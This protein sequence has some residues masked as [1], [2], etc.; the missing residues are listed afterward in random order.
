MP[1]GCGPA[2]VARRVGISRM[3]VYRILGEIAGPKG[4]GQAV[5]SRK[6]H[7]PASPVSQPRSR[8]S[9]SARRRS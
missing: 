1:E 9:S 5:R 2:E 3:S 6:P 4:I 7:L 8:R